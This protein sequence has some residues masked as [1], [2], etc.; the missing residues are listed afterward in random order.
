M[1]TPK[2]PFDILATNTRNSMMKIAVVLALGM[3]ILFNVFSSPLNTAAAPAGIVSFEFARTLE[4]AQVMITSWGEPGRL[5]AAFGLGLDFLYPLVYA[6][7]I[8]LACVWAVERIRPSASPMVRVG[9]LLAWGVWLAALLDYIENIALIQL[10]LGA[11]A[12]FW[13]LLAFI[14]AT[15]KFVLIII[16]ILY[17]PAAW[18]MFRANPPAV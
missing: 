8:S 12:E 11:T 14:C 3:T 6:S 7:A 9:I 2:A 5:V 18:M 4:N 15:I 10:L 17:V 13:P 1:T 16:G